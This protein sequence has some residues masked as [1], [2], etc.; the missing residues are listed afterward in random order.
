M[1]GRVLGQLKQ[2]GLHPFFYLS[3]MFYT[4]ENEG[5]DGGLIPAA[6]QYTAHYV[7]DEKTGKP[8]EFVLNES[9]P[10]W[11][12]ETPLLRVLRGLARNQG[13]SSAIWSTR[14]MPWG[15]DVLQMDQT[16]GGAG[17][18]CYST[19]H[20]HPAG[21]GLYQSR[22]FHSLLDAM[23]T[24]GKGNSPDFIL[25]HEEAHEQLIPH[26]DGFHVR[27]YKEKFWYRGQPGAIGIPL[28]SYLYHEY[29]IGYGGDSAGLS[30]DD[31]RLNVRSHAVNLITGR[32]PGAAIWSS[33]ASMYDAHP[34]QIA[35]LR[36]HSR[37]LKTRAGEYLMLGKMLHPC[38]VPTAGLTF[39]LPVRRGAKWEKQPLVTPAILTSSWQSPSGGIG[40]VFV[41]ISPT[42]QPL[43]VRLDTRN[44]PA[45]G[46]YD[47]EVYRSTA[48][49][50]F[51]PL[52]QNTALPKDFAADLAPLEVVFVEL[53]EKGR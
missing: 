48:G 13:V 29:A 53:R 25:L 42:V 35:M 7:V 10:S 51:K 26:L 17:H 32:T 30:K 12:L 5:R 43:K 38:E 45:A 23:R 21:N 4:Y 15:V 50:A 20:Q 31:N 49:E 39:D 41:N 47:A 34:N 2:E 19:L 40:H 52:W 8:R 28:F 6:S 24:R 46:S 33:P 22:D 18:A 44:V 3:G 9:N 27:E 36:N 37:L 11:H 16:T 1:P 14:L